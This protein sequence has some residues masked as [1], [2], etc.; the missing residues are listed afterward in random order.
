MQN[1]SPSLVQIHS[2]SDIYFRTGSDRHLFSQ[3]NGQIFPDLSDR[4]KTLSLEDFIPA[5][6]FLQKE[7]R[8]ANERFLFPPPGLRKWPVPELLRI[9]LLI[10]IHIDTHSHNHIVDPVHFPFIS[11]KIPQT[12]LPSKS[13]S[14]GHLIPV[15]IPVVSNM[16]WQTPTAVTMVIPPTVEAGGKVLKQRKDRC[17]FPPEKTSFCP[18]APVLPTVLPPRPKCPPGLPFGQLLGPVVGRIQNSMVFNFPKETFLP[19]AARTSAG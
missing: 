7:T 9:I 1:Q 11:V 12:F 17:P 10:P 6:K 13:R 14:L 4:G 19:K 5:G 15:Q 16:D 3:S 2:C 8:R 18:G